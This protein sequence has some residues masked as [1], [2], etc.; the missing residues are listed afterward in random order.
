M[1]S[2]QWRCN[3]PTHPTPVQTP[4]A[5]W[6]GNVTQQR[7]HLTSP[8][9]VSRSGDFLWPKKSAKGTSAHS[10]PGLRG[11]C[12]PPGPACRTGGQGGRSCPRPQ[13]ATRRRGGPAGTA[14]HAPD[15][16]Q[17]DAQTKTPALSTPPGSEHSWLRG[18][19]HTHQFLTTGPKR[20]RICSC[21][22]GRRRGLGRTGGPAHRPCHF[23]LDLELWR[24]SEP[25]PM[26]PSP[27]N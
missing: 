1:Y 10:E 7:W 5:V 24:P 16:W 12:R 17:V 2:L 14:R 3:V 22:F 25:T 20:T 9:N 13:L 11:P 18:P 21:P 19:S 4:L 6:P 8:L 27:G 26:P 23:R 15:R